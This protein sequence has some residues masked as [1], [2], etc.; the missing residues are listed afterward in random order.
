MTFVKVRSNTRRTL[1]SEFHIKLLRLSLECLHLL[2]CGLQGQP[3]PH[4]YSPDSTCI[5]YMYAQRQP[6][7]LYVHDVN[8]QHSPSPQNA[9]CT[10]G[11]LLKI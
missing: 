3:S 11:D 6:S 5:V 7:V 8:C 2:L 9:S 10:L 1:C 4:Q